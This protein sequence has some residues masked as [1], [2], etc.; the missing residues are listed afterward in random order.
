MVLVIREVASLSCA[1]EVAGLPTTTKLPFGVHLAADSWMLAW[2]GALPRALLQTVTRDTGAILAWARR[3]TEAVVW[4]R[5]ITRLALA[6]S[7]GAAAA[8]A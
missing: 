3:W 4:E 8:V 1:R 5:E 7:L 2:R 6:G